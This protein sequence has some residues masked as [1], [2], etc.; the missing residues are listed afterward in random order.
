M[1]EG[2]GYFSASHT[3]FQ[4][5]DK[6]PHPCTFSGL[7]NGKDISV[8]LG[9]NIPSGMVKAAEPHARNDKIPQG[10]VVAD[11]GS[12]RLAWPGMQKLSI[13]LW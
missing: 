10:K 1:A 2:G 7:R 9:K 4:G 6:K 5:V 8:P 11:H 3:N 13:C 12:I